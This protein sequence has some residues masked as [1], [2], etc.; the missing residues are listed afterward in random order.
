MNLYL[1]LPPI[2][3]HPPDTIRSLIHGR[4]RAYFLHNTRRTSFLN[5]CCLL[6][7]YLL[8]RGWQ[9][10]DI[11]HH[12]IKAHKDLRAAGKLKLLHDSKL[13]RREKGTTNKD[14]KS[15]IVF[16]LPYHPR[17]ISCKQIA[18]AYKDSGL[19]AAL[20]EK[21]LITAQ[22]RPYNIRDRISSTSLK[23]LPDEKPSKYV[24]Y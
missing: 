11:K 23:L 13:T 18:K 16:K 8:K 20:L 7:K 1:Y 14:C 15:T 19:A 24:H 2:T 22:L 3:A 17:G 10:S 6:A 9:W 4:V 21:R 12:F 5:E